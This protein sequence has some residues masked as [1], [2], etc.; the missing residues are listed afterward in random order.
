MTGVLTPDILHRLKAVPDLFEAIGRQQEPEMKLQQ[1][2]RRTH[3]ADLVRAALMVAA[4]RR[5][6]EG[7]LDRAEHLWLTAASLEQ[8]THPQVAVHRARR[9]P[10]GMPVADWCSGIGVD[11]AALARRGPVT[12]GDIDPAM[13]L[14]CEWTQE[15]WGGDDVQY[16]L[17][18]ARQADVAREWVYADPDRRCGR[19]RP[20]RRLEQYCPDLN[21][22]QKVTQSAAGGAIKVGP[23]AN[24]M[25]KFPGC[26]IEL[27]S[28]EG[29]CR[30]ATVWFGEA[31]G[32]CPFRATVLPDGETIAGDPLSWRAEIA[33]EP[34]RYL[35]D[36]D[37]AV[38]RSG[39]LDAVCDRLKL[40]R[41]DDREEYLTGDV[42]VESALIRPFSVEMVLSGN[43][44]DL[45]RY[46]RRF[47]G[48]YYE[49]KCRHLS[50]RAND[51]CRRLPAGGDE[52]KVVFFLRIQG[53]TR[54]VVARRCTR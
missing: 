27:V 17:A 51:V 28:L 41:L 1:R 13:L 14:C 18:D 24:F 2:L 44:R 34:A 37:P 16:R 47:P 3:D 11:T 21:W 30:E 23:A 33:S 4:G 43:E 29:E 15:V 35:F 39:L 9:F 10:S 26:E 48:Q 32:D 22:M 42:P 52:P 12:A 8:A 36:P 45:R 5:K 54:I 25:Q 31:A 46:L 53:R 50:V 40:Q 38:V 6:A 49:V 19:P 20:V 7:I